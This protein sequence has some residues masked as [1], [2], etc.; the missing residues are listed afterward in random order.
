MRDMI[1]GGSLQR[2]ESEYYTQLNLDWCFYLETPEEGHGQCHDENIR[3][4]VEYANDKVDCIDVD[5]SSL[6]VGIPYCS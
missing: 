1:L 3:D 6:Y 4:Y 5:A 2:T